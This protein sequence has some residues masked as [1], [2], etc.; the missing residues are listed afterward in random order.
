MGVKVEKSKSRKVKRSNWL[1]KFNK[2]RWVNG[3]VI[4][5]IITSV[6]VVLPLVVIMPS[7]LVKGDEVWKHI[8]HRLLPG[9]IKNTVFLMIGVGI[10]T[11]I[12]GLVPAWLVT[13]YR[14]RGRKIFQWALI[15]PIA[16]PA[17]ING[18]TWAGIL[19]Y[20]SP[21]YVFFR[22]NFG[23]DTGP[24]LFFNIHSLTG[25]IIILSLSL[26][27]YVYLITRAWFLRQSTIL[28]EASASLGRKPLSTFFKVVLPLT[29]PA[30]V[31][32]VSLVLMEVLNEY[33][34]VR[35]FGVDTFTTGIFTAWFAFGSPASAM[36]LATY[37]MVI[38]LGLILLERYQRRQKRY[39][40]IGGNYCPVKPRQMTVVAATLAIIF[41]MIPL[42]AGFAIPATMLG[43]WS[44]KTAGQVIDIRFWELLRNS[45]LLATATSIL[46]AVIALLVAFTSRT[47][48]GMLVSLLSRISTIG[49]AIPGAVVAI[50]IMM[51]ILWMEQQSRIWMPGI[52]LVLTGSIVVLVFAY[53]VRFMAVGYN[54]IESGMARVSTSLDEAARSLGHSNWRNLWQINIPLLKGSLV[55]AVLLVFIDVLKELP[56]TLI[57]RPFNFDTLAIRAF[58]FASDE[59]I[60]EAAP[61]AFIIILVGLVPVYLLNRMLE[62]G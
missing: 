28:F 27:P 57:M 18:F 61:A 1:A 56:I 35:Y 17:Y 20:T 8:L 16:I 32:G 38:V 40:L 31:A 23:V 15:L 30:L 19:D 21:V 5:A 50:G 54:P 49:Y 46:V 3:W 13:M 60:A 26:Y 51:F 22:N 2:P 10:L 48:P 24:Y 53:M 11:I 59:R 58:E 41:C 34:L 62:R 45:F 29:R 33:G 7:L 14:F 36:K 9:Y 43:A 42:A 52:E 12:F 37:L 4:G 47:F 44:L 55:S 39:D 25:A 6:F